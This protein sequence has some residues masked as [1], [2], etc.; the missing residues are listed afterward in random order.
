[1]AGMSDNEPPVF[2]SMAA[3]RF[4]LARFRAGFVSGLFAGCLIGAVMAS[5][6]HE[7]FH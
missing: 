7:F 2:L 3:H 5:T 4:C 1:M 6:I